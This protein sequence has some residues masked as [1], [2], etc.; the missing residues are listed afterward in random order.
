MLRTFIDF[1]TA[2]LEFN[3][4]ISSV[5]KMQNCIS[6]KIISVMIVRY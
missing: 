2:K 5:I 6:L 3:Q 4:R 1:R